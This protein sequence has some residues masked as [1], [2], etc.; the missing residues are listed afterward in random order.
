MTPSQKKRREKEAEREGR[1]QMAQYRDVKKSTSK[2]VKEREKR[3]SNNVAFGVHVA[4]LAWFLTGQHPPF[5]EPLSSKK[6]RRRRRRERRKNSA[7]WGFC[8]VTFNRSRFHTPF[9]VS[10]PVKNLNVKFDCATFF[11]SSSSIPGTGYY[12]TTVLL[13][14]VIT[15]NDDA[16]MNDSGH[17]TDRST[18]PKIHTHTHTCVLI[19]LTD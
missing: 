2:E 11:F 6:G 4:N 15:I 9:S 14:Y 13:Q 3:I 12:N 17:P 5:P 19:Y 16:R 8:S 7:F 1:R 18:E 10:I